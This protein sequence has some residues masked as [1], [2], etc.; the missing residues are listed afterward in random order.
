MLLFDLLG[1]WTRGS[2][3]FFFFILGPHMQ[4]MKVPRPGVKLE[5]Q[6]M[7]HPSATATLDLRRICDLCCSLWQHWIINSLSGARD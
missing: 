2:P 3:F 5:L 6:L 7:A 4:H 1:V